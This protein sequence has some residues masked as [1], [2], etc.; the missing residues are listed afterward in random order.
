MSKAVTRCL[1]LLGRLLCEQTTAFVIDAYVLAPRV[2]AEREASTTALLHFMLHTLNYSAAVTDCLSVVSRKA[3]LHVRINGVNFPYRDRLQG[4]NMAI[5][6]SAIAPSA[7]SSPDKFAESRPPDPVAAADRPAP[8]LSQG[9]GSC[10][11][12]LPHD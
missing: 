5:A 12:C 11:L 10:R 7:N 3:L 2:L 6:D 8:H 4:G 1:R 9:K